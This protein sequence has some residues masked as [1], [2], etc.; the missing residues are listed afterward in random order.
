MRDEKLCQEGW[1]DAS[2]RE[3]KFLRNQPR[4]PT[5]AEAEAARCCR[6]QRRHAICQPETHANQTTKS[7]LGG[8]TGKLLRCFARFWSA[9]E[10]VR[11]TGFAGGMLACGLGCI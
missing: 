5:L 7:Q 2:R 10:P 3:P 9:A 11:R 6:E 1:E 4:E 8:G